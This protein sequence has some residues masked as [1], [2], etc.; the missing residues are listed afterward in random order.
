MRAGRIPL[1][2]ADGAVVP[3]DLRQAALEFGGDLADSG[4]YLHRMHAAGLL[5]VDEHG[6]VELS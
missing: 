2:D 5:K 6:V 1:R 4:P 3:V